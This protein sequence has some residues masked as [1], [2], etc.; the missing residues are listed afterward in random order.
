MARSTGNC[1]GWIASFSAVDEALDL[2]WNPFK[3]VKRSLYAWFT[4]MSQANLRKCNTC[5]GYGFVCACGTVVPASSRLNDGAVIVC[6]S[7]GKDIM[8]RNPN[9]LLG[10]PPD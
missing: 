4:S 1:H 10:S 2:H 7:C 6:P 9:H 3:S 5:G 8:V